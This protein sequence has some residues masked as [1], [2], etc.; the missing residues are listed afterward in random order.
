MA[1]SS[2]TS[3]K[4]AVQCTLRGPPVSISNLRA[5]D[6]KHYNFPPSILQGFW[7]SEIRDPRKCSPKHLP[8]LPCLGF[9]LPLATGLK[10]VL[11]SVFLYPS[12]HSEM[13]GFSSRY[14]NTGNCEGDT[15]SLKPSE[16]F[17][18]AAF[19]GLRG[20][21]P[22]CACRKGQNQEVAISDS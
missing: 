1:W 21:V 2:S 19:E 17:I 5:Q 9:L 8:S 4:L 18:V 10:S 12:H 6:Y 20:S 15:C 16:V 14:E 11:F 22:H 7:E 13:V 3:T